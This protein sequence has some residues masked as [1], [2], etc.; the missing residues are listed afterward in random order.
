MLLGE[1]MEIIGIITV[2]ILFGWLAVMGIAIN[3]IP[4]EM[5]MYQRLLALAWSLGW[6]YLWWIFVGLRI[7]VSFN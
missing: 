3:M 1:Q 2:T 4:A 7:E 6:I 5:K